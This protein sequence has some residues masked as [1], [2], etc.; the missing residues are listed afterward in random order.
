LPGRYR[1]TS[2]PL[3]T[4]RRIEL[5][6]VLLAVVLGLQL[7]Y[8]G[9]RVKMLSLPDAVMP[10]RDALLV[11]DLYPMDSIT[12]EQSDELLARPLFWEGRRPR[13]VEDTG[14]RRNKDQAAGQLK[15]VRLQ[16]VFGAGETAGVIIRIKDQQRRVMV[17]EEINGWTVESVDAN[18]VVLSSRG[19]T[20]SL[21]LRTGIV[22]ARATVPVAPAKAAPAQRGFDQQPARQSGTG[23]PGR[24][25]A[26]E[27]G[28]DQLSAGGSR[29]R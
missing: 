29:L 3:R 11:G 16:G 8:S 21:E 12:S 5:A 14:A 17:G 10:A 6:V 2:D 20:Q 1:V 24:E 4:E 23:T 28:E 7:L 18:E 25:S 15:N 22:A 13:A 26:A 19:R 9:A 27:A